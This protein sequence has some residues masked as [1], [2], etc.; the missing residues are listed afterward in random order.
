MQASEDFKKRILVVE[1]EGQ[2]A[3]DLRRRIERM[4]YPPPSL[5]RSGEEALQAARST[6]FDLALV[7][8]RLKGE[9]DG[10]AT[11]AA[12]RFES[13]APVVYLTAHADQETIERA[14]LTEPLGCIP[15]PISDDDLR[16]VIETAIYKA[17]MERRLRTAA[18]WLA[19]TMRSVGEGIVATDSDGEVVFVNPCAERLTGW[20]GGRAHGRQLMDVLRLY[21]ESTDRPAGNPVFDLGEGESRSF[22]LISQTGARALVEVECFE[23]R[24]DEQVLGSIVVL[25]EIGHRRENDRRLLQAQRMEAIANLAAGLAHDFNNQLMV[26]LG[27]AEELIARLAGED[28]EQIREIRQAASLAASTTA[29]LLAL[30]RR[31]G[32]GFAA[33]NLHEV[34]REVQPLIAQSLGDAATLTTELGSPSGYIRGDRGRIR[35][36]LLHLTL[37]A[38][39]AMRA[40]GEMRIETA[41]LDIGGDDPMARHYRPGTY[42]KLHVFHNGEGMDPATMA[43]VFEP[44]FGAGNGLGLSLVH[45][46]VIES[47]GYIDVKSALDKGTRFEILLPCVGMLQG[48]A[49]D[50]RATVLLV[51]EEDSARRLMHR[52]L[53]REGYRLLTA[54]NAAAA[55]EIAAAYQ[56]DIHVLVTDG[57][58]LAER[59][60]PRYPEMKVLLVG[61]YRHDDPDQNELP[62]RGVPIL[63]KPFPPAQLLRQVRRLLS[64]R[65]QVA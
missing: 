38:R 64:R 34:I 60:K 15:Q 42:V 8:I 24:S 46:I 19:T 2:I 56:D 50:P 54:R 30:S 11:A 47:G 53:E 58:E 22:S 35:Q 20:L 6:P 26:I 5:A 7:D 44:R 61:G 57:F 12:L 36:L 43:R 33:L 52:F 23:N 32:E 31:G 39:S 27:Y 65:V 40:A 37:H 3:D 51:E 29:Q 9:M 13:R 21:E 16:C 1:N 48:S 18:A 4:G 17:A 25:R 49:D 55:E 63:P 14:K 45:G 28:R 10:V 62:G 41:T 59:L